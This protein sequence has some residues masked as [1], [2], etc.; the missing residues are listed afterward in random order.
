MKLS[1]FKNNTH[2]D[3]VDLSSE[4]IGL[5]D[6]EI[7]FY[8]GRSEDCHIHL[9]DKK[10]SREHARISFKS[11]SWKINQVS[12]FGGLIINGV[13]TDS[14]ELNN[15][16][17]VTIGP[18]VINTFGLLN[19]A[20]IISEPV[21][22]LSNETQTLP[23]SDI[24]DQT[25]T[26]MEQPSDT[27]PPGGDADNTLEDDFIINGEGDQV[28]DN[29]GF[30]SNES[31]STEEEVAVD[32]EQLAESPDFTSTDFGDSNNS[33]DDFDIDGAPTNT[34]PSDDEGSVDEPTGMFNLSEEGFD[35]ES[36]DDD[37]LFGDEA[38][39]G[40]EAGNVAEEGFE[41][42]EYTEEEFGVDTYG[43]DDKT[44]VMS[45]FARFELEIFGELAPFDKFIVDKTET[46]IG[47]DPEKCDIIL[48]DPEVSGQ[49]AILKKN[50]IT[51]VIE[52]LNSGNGTLL[53][54]ERI[55]KSGLTNNDEFIIGSTTFTVHVISELIQQESERLMPVEEN[56][57]V[58]VEEIVE[59]SEDY[60]E[61]TSVRELFAEKSGGE[62]ALDAGATASSGSFADKLKDPEK[63]KKL[64]IYAVV[65]IG[66]W[67]ML[68]EE[69]PVKK[70]ISKEEKSR[71]LDKKKKI[72]NSKNKLIKK[73]NSE[74]LEFLEGTYLLAKEFIDQGKYRE[75]LSELD[76]IQLK[77][78]QANIND[79]KQTSTL[80]E[81]A[82]QG[83]SKLEELE[84]KQQAE[85]DRKQRMAKVKE[86][87]KRAQKAVKERKSDAAEAF[88]S[89][90][91]ELDP[92]NFDIPQL[93]I[94]IEAWKKEQD[95]IAIEKAQKEADRKRMV[96]ALAPGKSFYL[97]KEW[98]KA[99]LK[100][101]DF[102]RLKQMDE[103]LVTDATKMLEESKKTISDIVNPLI[104]KARSLSEGQDLKGAYE[105]YAEIL[106]T[107]PTYDEAL[108][109]MNEIREKLT[110]RSRK[111]YREALISESLSLF[112]DAKEKFQEVQQIAPSDSDYYKKATLKL[113]DYLD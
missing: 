9:D 48:N 107:D 36:K 85:I 45:A 81:V 55:N 75:S 99:V 33:D 53:N 7:S 91:L 25:N 51:C 19:S 34:V 67:V 98:Y 24:N 77:L 37:E 3:E 90:I 27:S 10:V 113:K 86:L 71:L 66:L 84:R 38:T 21:D 101:E 92:D 60:A 94:E 4:I 97:K 70:I 105:V 40:F 41:D 16:D 13:L 14:K 72:K 20:Q 82:K 109:E 43:D 57:M 64:L 88:F 78:K 93:K 54:G 5:D 56:Q 49:H 26:I 89:Q 104:G 110:I 80:R 65:L 1:V 100:L 17:V 58:E 8:I 59:V 6:S 47:R 28:I 73:F 30:T 35:P 69:K 50:N 74:E 96:D 112:N 11:G 23:S 18:Y 15:G 102:L 42:G 22:M 46:I 76:K 79:Y 68:D 2:L 31:V 62:F 111:I 12:G 61:K 44:Q 106:E 29:P 52:D 83:L 32:E 108:N 39:E 63:R 95:R 87:V 103:D